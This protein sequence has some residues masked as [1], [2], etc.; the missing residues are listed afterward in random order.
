MTDRDRAEM[1]ALCDAF[2]KTIARENETLVFDPGAK[3]RIGEMIGR[4]TWEGVA[5]FGYLGRKA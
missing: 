1:R 4:A 5:D 2:R 3:Q